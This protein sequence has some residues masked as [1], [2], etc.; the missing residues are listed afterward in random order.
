[1][2]NENFEPVEHDA[3]IDPIFYNVHHEFIN[4]DYNKNYDD[5]QN[6][7]DEISDNTMGKIDINFINPSTPLV[8]PRYTCDR[9]RKSFNSRNRFFAHLRLNCWKFNANDRLLHEKIITIVTTETPPNVTSLPVIIFSTTVVKSTGYAFKNWHYAVL[10]MHWEI[11][12]FKPTDTYAN[13]GCM[14]FMIDRNYFQVLPTW[15]NQTHGIQ[16]TNP[17]HRHINSL[18]RRICRFNVLPEKF[19]KRI[20]SRNSYHS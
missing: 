18:L 12:C 1:M 7:G 3:L 13:N 10:Q 8:E 16:N 9:C 15:Q 20:Q 6:Y 2:S 11:D 14:M 4:D 17:W 5:Y 19:F